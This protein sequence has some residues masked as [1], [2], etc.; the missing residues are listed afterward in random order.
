[1]KQMTGTC[2]FC[3]QTRMVEADTQEEANRIASENCTCDNKLKSCRQCSE[4]I[5]KICGATAKEFGMDVVVE[6][7]IEEI[8]AVG[9]LCVY[10]Y[11]EVASF[12]L[13]DST[14]A[15]KQ[16]K[17]GVSVARKKVSSVKLEA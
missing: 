17:D 6:D 4:N 1:M 11:I 10:G 13:A 16:I 8:K 2:L 9:K 14:I 12:R 7:V 5:D 15:I 3:G